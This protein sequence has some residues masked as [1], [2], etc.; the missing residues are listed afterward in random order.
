MPIDKLLKLCSACQAKGIK[1]WGELQS[2]KDA[3]TDGTNSDML[4][5]LGAE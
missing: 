1:T 4:K 5:K 2:F 3:N